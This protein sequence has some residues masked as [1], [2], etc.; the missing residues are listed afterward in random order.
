MF[1]PATFELILSFGEQVSKLTMCKKTARLLHVLCFS[2][3]LFIGYIYLPPNTLSFTTL[4]VVRCH[5]LF[6]FLAHSHNKFMQRSKHM[7]VYDR[8]GTYVGQVYHNGDVHDRS[9]NGVGTVY[10]NGDV[11]NRSGYVGKV[12][13]DGKI[14]GTSY[15]GHIYAE[16]SVNDRNDRHAGRVSG[17]NMFSST[18]ERY[19]AGGAALLLLLKPTSS[20]AST[21]ISVSSSPRSTS[22]ATSASKDDSM[23]TCLAIF[24]WIGLLSLVLLLL[25]IFLFHNAAL[26]WIG[27]IGLAITAFVG[28]GALLADE[29]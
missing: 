4:T 2:G 6:Q 12:Y 7:D 24:G 20:R 25:G 9:G 13:H 14:S 5:L 1:L 18:E 28:F 11:H 8:Q 29:L 10:H 3:N 23:E 17:I 19:Y 21:P 27:G 26:I 15:G 16:G 22:T